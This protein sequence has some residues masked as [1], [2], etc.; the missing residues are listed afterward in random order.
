MGHCAFAN[1]PLRLSRVIN[2]RLSPINRFSLVVNSS[3]LPDK[4]QI[5]HRIP[6][7]VAAVMQRIHDSGFD[8]W[9]VGGA[10]R[11]LLRGEEPKDWD[12]ATS[13]QPGQI[14]RLFRTVVPIGIQH[15]TVMI[16]SP[17]RGI[18]TTSFTPGGMEGILS[19]LGR[20]DFS[21]NAM[22]IS[23]PEAKLLDPHHGAADLKSMIL[24]GVGDPGQRFRED[25]LRTLRAG[26]FISAYGF[27][28]EAKTL[29]AL[30]AES[31]GLSR[32]A[33]ERIREELL[34]LISGEHVVDSLLLMDLSGVLHE[35][36]PELFPETAH[37]DTSADV[38]ASRTHR[39]ARLMHSVPRRA[40]MRM[41]AL[42]VGAAL[43][44]NRSRLACPEESS[45]CMELAAAE[46][47][48]RLRVP[49]DFSR[50][51]LFLL[52][53]RVPEGTH[54]WSDARVR[55][56]ISHIGVSC[57]QNVLDLARAERM[58]L[59][60][61][62]HPEAIDLLQRRMAAQIRENHPFAIGDLPVNGRDV[63]ETLGIGPGPRVGS[64]LEELLERVHHD[65][66]MNDRNILIDFLS[67][68]VHKEL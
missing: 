13:A 46:I 66:G 42:F 55:A 58:A 14:V 67:K 6:E 39:I 3:P 49:N 19:D 56:F 40:P 16:R 8:V 25:P 60:D 61:R 21:V 2:N 24:R 47:L 1:I 41:A 15:G 50:E 63:M 45:A 17:K 68:K 51:V 31:H 18:E 33:P 10:V 48:S 9:L 64:I 53:H 62:E 34:K 59:P 11:D 35:I 65:P 32:V 7:D 23:F 54:G 12:L 27:I 44:S 57:L 52:K 4:L 28:A 20:R 38:R 22:A 5:L 37:E 30:K 36:L 29:E 26:R 43:F